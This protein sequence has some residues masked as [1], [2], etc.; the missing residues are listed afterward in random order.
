MNNV[1]VN[2]FFP[3]DLEWRIWEFD[4]FESN[5]QNVESFLI[6][7]LK[8]IQAYTHVITPFVECVPFYKIKR[9]SNA[10]VIAVDHNLDL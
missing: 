4:N 10:K 7:F 6:L 3:I 1:E 2:W 8:I 9:F 5:N